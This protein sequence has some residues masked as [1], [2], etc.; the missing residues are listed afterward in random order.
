MA[1]AL[2]SGCGG[3]SSTVSPASYVKAV[4]TSFASFRTDIRVKS[5]S[6]GSATLSNPAQGKQALQSFLSA[7]ASSAD[8]TAAKLKSAG[9]P[10]VGNGKSIASSITN[11]FSQLGSSLNKSK[12]AADAL[13]TSSPAAFKPGALSVLANIRTSLTSLLGGLSGL[14]SPA[15]DQAAKNEPACKTLAG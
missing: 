7:A 4:C 10:N 1:A 13:P 8:Q 9:T 12:T 15:L 14:K 2:I 11:A 5:S 3:S 6:L